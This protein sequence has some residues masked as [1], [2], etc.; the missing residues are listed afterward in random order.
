FINERDFAI[1]HDGKEIYYTISTPKSSFQTIVVR[2]KADNGN[3]TSPEVVSFAGQYSDLEPA[4]SADGKTLYFS[5]NRPLTGDQPKDFDIWKVSR[6]GEG[7]GEPVN[8]GI[9]INTSADEFY[10]SITV[11]GT[12]YFTAAYDGGIGKEDI[13]K[14]AFQNGEFQKPQVLDT[15][16]NSK[17]YEFN[18][19]VD[20]REQYILFTAY[21]R[22]DDMGGGDLYISTKNSKGDWQPAIHLSM[23][24]SRQLD[25]CPYVS[26][27]GKRLFF[28]SD[29]HELPKS[30]PAKNATYENVIEVYTDPLN[31]TGNIYWVDF[32]QVLESIKR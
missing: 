24:N 26:L 23:L 20:P 14:S 1:S 19:F 13:Y 32:E 28:T 30:F 3:W 9:P 8:L 12:I 7:W 10:P 11:G 5:S 18:A 16:V 25:Y 4:F 29:R 17:G 22:Q 6:I 15:M 31:G 21:G 27:D 2:H